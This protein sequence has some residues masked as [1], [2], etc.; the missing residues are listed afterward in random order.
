L[1]LLN[2]VLI[3][4]FSRELFVFVSPKICEV[5]CGILLHRGLDLIEMTC[6]WYVVVM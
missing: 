4:K 1:I 3:T 5:T 6:G 2:R